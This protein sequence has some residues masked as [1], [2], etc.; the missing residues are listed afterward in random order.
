MGFRRD[1]NTD[2]DMYFGDCF[3]KDERTRS[4]FDWSNYIEKLESTTIRGCT[5]LK[6]KQLV[7]VGYFLE[8]CY[9]LC[10]SPRSNVSNNPGFEAILGVINT[11]N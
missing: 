2:F 9:D 1:E 8:L 6:E 3:R 4:L 11:N 5:T 10:I 7:V